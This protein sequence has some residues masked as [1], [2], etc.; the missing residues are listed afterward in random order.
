VYANGQYHGLDGAWH[1]DAYNPGTWTFLIYLNELPDCELDMYQGTTDFKE[2]DFAFKSIQPTSN[3][4]LL[5]MSTLF[6][7]GMGPSRF[8]PDMRVTLAWKLREITN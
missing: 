7:R 3:S 5:F 1:Q 2:S 8:I 6:H 4:G